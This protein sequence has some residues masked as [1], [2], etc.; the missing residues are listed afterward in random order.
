MTVWHFALGLLAVGSVEGR[1]AHHHTPTSHSDNNAIADAKLSEAQQAA[2]SDQ[3]E[4]CASAY[5]EAYLWSHSTWQLRYNC[6]AGYASVLR[7]GHFP[8]SDYHRLI[9]QQIMDDQTAPSLHHAQV[10]VRAPQQYVR[11]TLMLTGT[12][13]RREPTSAHPPRLRRFHR[14]N[15]PWATSLT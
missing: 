13:T 15:S 7:E 2:M 3:W 8:P 9:L 11:R 5:L 6:L 14:R 10:G 4:A 12:R 1:Q